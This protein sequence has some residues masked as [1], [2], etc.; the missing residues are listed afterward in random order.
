MTTTEKKVCPWLTEDREEPFCG[1]L[2]M[3]LSGEC[4]TCVNNPDIE[5]EPKKE[6]PPSLPNMTPELDL[7]VKATIHVSEGLGIPAE[8]Y[9]ELLTACDG[10]VK[11]LIP[12]QNPEEAVRIWN[13]HMGEVIDQYPPRE[14][15][16]LGSLVALALHQMFKASQPKVDVQVVTQEEYNKIMAGSDGEPDD[17]ESETKYTITGKEAWLKDQYRD[18]V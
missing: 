1:L 11:F 17:E 3:P 12:I 8:R 5:D 13:A 16:V 15:A 4:A 6:Y 9:E 14:A 7:E 10:I 18:V 2:A